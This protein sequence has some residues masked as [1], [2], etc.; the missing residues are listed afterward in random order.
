MLFQRPCLASHQ[1]PTRPTGIQN[2]GSNL[3]SSISAEAPELGPFPNNITV[4]SPTRA[5]SATEQSANGHGLVQ[6]LNKRSCIECRRR[7]TRC[8]KRYPCSRCTKTSKQCVFPHS[9]RA[10][11]INGSTEAELTSRLRRLEGIVQKLGVNIEGDQENEA[12][13]EPREANDDQEHAE[14]SSQRS[15]AMLNGESGVGWNRLVDELGK[16]RYVNSEHWKNLCHEVSCGKRVRRQ[17]M[18]ND[19]QVEDLKRLEHVWFEEE[20]RANESD[21]SSKSMTSVYTPQYDACFLFRLSS[22]SSDLLMMHPTQ[23]QIFLLWQ[24]YLENVDPLLKI[25]H[26]PTV[27]RLIL[28]ASQ[29]MAALSRENEALLFAV[30]Y[31]AVM[32]MQQD[33]CQ[34]LLKNDKIILSSKYRFGTEQALARAGFLETR[35]LTVLQAFVLFLVGS[36]LSGLGTC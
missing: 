1:G 34:T 18:I 16:Y 12:A 10:R 32:S 26:R 9:G 36:E 8:D 31:G 20:E 29:D 2:M 30:Y 5:I 14:I 7:K 11:K 35:N 21:T 6:G 22:L 13:H 15:A 19:L 3:A 27:Q 24:I 28:E 4:T 33:E 25:F 17:A 23:G